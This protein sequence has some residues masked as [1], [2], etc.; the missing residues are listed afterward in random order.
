VVWERYTIRGN[1]SQEIKRGGTYIA[2]FDF[3]KNMSCPE[4]KVDYKEHNDGNASVPEET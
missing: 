4:N 1:K 3:S 2:S